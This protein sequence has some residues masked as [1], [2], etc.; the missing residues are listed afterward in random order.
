M[1]RNA[2]AEHQATLTRGQKIADRIASGAGSWAFIITCIAALLAW[3]R[4]NSVQFIHPFDRAPYILLNLILSM[5]AAIQA[6]IILMSQNRQSDRDRI[7][8]HIDF[9][10]NKKAEAEIRTVANDIRKM[11]ERLAFLIKVIDGDL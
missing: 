3:V 1:I 10:V 6:P 4:V 2:H 5:L 8:A 7:A 11:N 9:E